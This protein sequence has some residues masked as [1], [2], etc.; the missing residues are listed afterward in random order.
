MT[1][2]IPKKTNEPLVE[3]P[4]VA[5][6]LAIAAGALDGYA[7]FTT[8]LFATFQSGNIILTGFTIATDDMTK[9]YPTLYS[10]GAFSLGAMALAFLR[11]SYINKNKTWSFVALAFEMVVLLILATN[12]FHE[13]FSPLHIVFILAFI[14]GFQGNAFHYIDKMLYGNIAVTLNVQLAAS[15]FGEW[16][17]KINSDERKQKFKNFFDYFIILIGFAF[18]AFVSAILAKP[19]GSYTL[20][21]PILSLAAI[22]IVGKRYHKK[23][24]TVQID[25]N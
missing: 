4:I 8:K 18:G 25:A 7:Y 3:L 2:S 9:L 5:F 6:F 22:Y 16:L 24:P 14:A 17:M 20:I 21:I 19:I 10:I 11:D 1:N 13:L 23:N 15:Y 12:T